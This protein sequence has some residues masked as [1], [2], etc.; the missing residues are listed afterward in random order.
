MRANRKSACRLAANG[1]SCRVAAKPG[2]ILVNPAKSGLLIHQAEIARIFGNC[3]VSK[4]A[5]SAESIVETDPY[6]ISFFN[7]FRHVRLI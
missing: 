6:D 4:K 2:N 1:H 7:N 5:Q 3:R